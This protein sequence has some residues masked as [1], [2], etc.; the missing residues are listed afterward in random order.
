MNARTNS[1]DLLVHFGTMM[2]TFLTSSGNCELDTRRMPSS[3]TSDLSETLVRL[4]GQ[5]LGM[6]SRSHTCTKKNKKNTIE[7]SGHLQIKPQVFF[8]IGKQKRQKEGNTII[9]ILIQCGKLRLI[10]TVFICMPIINFQTRAQ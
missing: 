4:S 3:N 10:I 8:L 9:R 5:L 2:I 7:S 1:V 6:P